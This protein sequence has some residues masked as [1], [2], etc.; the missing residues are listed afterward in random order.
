MLNRGPPYSV[1]YEH[2]RRI[3]TEDMAKVV[4]AVWGTE[5]IQ[6]LSVLAIFSPGRF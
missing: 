5:F 6:F 3:F 1:Q 2:R 4:A